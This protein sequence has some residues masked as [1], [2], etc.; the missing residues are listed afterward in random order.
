M[1]YPGIQTV[2]TI[3]HDKETAADIKG[4]YVVTTDRQ[5]DEAWRLL[6]LFKEFA[7]GIRNGS[8]D[9]QVSNPSA[10]SATGLATLT[11]VQIGDI[12]MINGI[13]FTA[14][15]S[16]ATGNQFNIGGSDAITATNLAAAI[17]AS[18]TPGMVGIIASTASTNV[19]TV[20]TIVPGAFGNDYDI[21]ARGSGAIVVTGAGAQASS[22]LTF[23]NAGAATDTLTLNG[24]AFTAVASGATGNQWN[25]GGSAALSATAAAA[26]INASVST[27]VLGE[28]YAAAAG[29]VVTVRA[30]RSG[31]Y[32]NLETVAAGQASITALGA[33][34]TG[35]ADPAYVNFTGGVNNT[36]NTYKYGV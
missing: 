27:L 28:V 23:A 7:S 2:V 31:I 24:I 22:T 19:V 35:G 26:A 16:G 18:A 5:R 4:L 15:A 10:V 36:A 14:V 6:K 11:G 33:R 34:M 25:V 17:V 21:E 9:V 20:T 8:I 12:L 30:T 1:P 13:A 3:T 32:G 29:A